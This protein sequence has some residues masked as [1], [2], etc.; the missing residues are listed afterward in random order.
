MARGG[1]LQVGVH[2]DATKGTEEFREA[3]RDINRRM[4]VALQ[5]AGEK[6][7]LPRARALA[8]SFIAPTLVVRARR[9]SA[10]ITTRL[11]GKMARVAGLLHWGGTVRAPIRPQGAKALFWPGASHPVAEVTGPRTYAPKLYLSKAVESARP[12]INRVVLEEIMG[13]FDGLEHG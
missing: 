9:S 3:R 4:R 11:R 6:A 12:R 2:I 5:R 8:P 7:V 1:G 10:V 13:A